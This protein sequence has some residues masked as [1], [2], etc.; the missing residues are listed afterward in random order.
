VLENHLLP[1]KRIH[2][3]THFL[4]DGSPSQGSKK[5]KTFLAM[6]MFQVID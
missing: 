4:Q 2:G 3:S 5:I 1:F 6:Q